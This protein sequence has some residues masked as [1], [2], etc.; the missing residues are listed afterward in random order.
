M[1]HKARRWSSKEPQQ[2]SSSGPSVFQGHL[3][4]HRVT[5]NGSHRDFV[6]ERETVLFVLSPLYVRGLTYYPLCF[7]GRFRSLTTAF[8]RDAMGFLLMFD[9]TSQQS[10]LNVRNWM[11]KWDRITCVGHFG[12]QDLYVFACLPYKMKEQPWEVMSLV[13]PVSPSKWWPL[14]ASP[15]VAWNCILLWQ[16]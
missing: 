7:L 14:C 6:L 11:S 15:K 13:F 4:F 12:T 9:L 5:H 3:L 1:G 16:S 10:F 8:F 2:T